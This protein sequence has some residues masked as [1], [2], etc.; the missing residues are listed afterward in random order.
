MSLFKHLDVAGKP[1]I[2]WEMTPEYTFGT[3][4]SWGGKE[5]LRNNNERFYYF[6]VDGWSKTPKLC[7]MERAVKY[8]RVLAEIKAPEEMVRRCVQEQ[9]RVSH[10]DRTFAVNQELKDW[11]VKNVIEADDDSL[12]VPLKEEEAPEIVASGLPLR[13]SEAIPEPVTQV[14][15]PQ[16]LRELDEADVDE[17]VAR[18]NFPDQER[19]PGGAFPHV[20]V[21]NGDDLTISDRATGLMWQRTGLDIMSCRL[22]RLAV[23]E[24]NRKGFAGFHDWRLPSLEEAMSLMENEKLANGQYLH[25]C[26]SA[27]APFVFA[28]APR[29]RGGHWFVDY[30]QGRIFWASAT[31]PG[32]FGRL[33]RTDE[34]IRRK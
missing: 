7:L 4:E 26:F 13:A 18:Y 29:K 27:G 22:M 28:N 30:K 20:F 14:W 2:D 16:G 8:A 10:Y 33:C 11:L 23:D 5:R 25:R 21:D 15:L 12:V 6:F 34:E 32:G 3:F 31:I 1:Q 17:A 24:L 19:N 9:G